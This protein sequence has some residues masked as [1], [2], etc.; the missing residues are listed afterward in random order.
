M[1]DTCVKCGTVCVAGTDATYMDD[2]ES[3][4]CDNCAGIVRHPDGTWYQSEA[5]YQTRIPVQLCGSTF[6]SVRPGSFVAV[7]PT[8]RLPWK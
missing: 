8:R 3:I 7:H 1:V 2:D 6:R 4:I 5:P